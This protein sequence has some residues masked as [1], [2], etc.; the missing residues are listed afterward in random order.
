MTT[1]L[2]GKVA[3]VTG[4]ASGIG[5]A[6]AQA[7][8]EFGAHVSGAD[9]TLG[10]DL[11]LDVTSEADWSRVI[12]GF[13]SLDI[14]VLSAGV[15]SAG[16]LAETSLQEWRRVMSV[17]L[18]GA[19]L[20]IRAALKKMESGG[21]IVLL[22]SASGVKPVA[23][24]GAYCSSKAGLR[25]LT[26]VAALEGKPKGI[27]VNCVSPAG[28]ATPMWKTMDFFQEFA[29]E[30]EA[31]KALGGIDPQTPALH[32]MALPSEIAEAVIFLCSPA[33]QGITGIDLPVD[34]GYSL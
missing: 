28:V 7:L 22:G 27:R 25:M 12:D 6:V 32:R 15:S 24:A 9:I 21:S 2:E 13:P 8:H 3:L 30:D 18:D 11:T 19:F 23:N 20:G 26:K 14:L 29:S 34:S 10:V 4:A 16:A 1:S 17:N 31:W 33:A 5:L